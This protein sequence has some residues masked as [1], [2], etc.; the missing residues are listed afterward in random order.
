MGVGVGATLSLGGN[1]FDSGPNRSRFLSTRF[2]RDLVS[3]LKDLEKTTARGLSLGLGVG[4]RP[5][6]GDQ[7]WL[8][9]HRCER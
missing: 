6:R 9:H 5:Y 1:R 8:Q 4:I 3:I 7:R 2:S